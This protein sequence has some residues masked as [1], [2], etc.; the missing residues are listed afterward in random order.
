MPV[1]V[2]LGEIQRCTHIAGGTWPQMQ[3]VT[4]D[5]VF[6]RGL[7]MTILGIISDWSSTSFRCVATGND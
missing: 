3:A 7:V 5:Y 1:V 6:N 4:K 2:W